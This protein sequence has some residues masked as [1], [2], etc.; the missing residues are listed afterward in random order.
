MNELNISSL[1]QI[2]QE[3]FVEHDKQESAGRFLLESVTLQEDSLCTT[4]L[5]S[6]KIS[7][8]VKR[9]DPVPDDI[10]QAALK[11]DIAVKVEEYFRQ[12][13]IPDINPYTKDDM[14]QKIMN[15]IIQ[16]SEIA[17]RKKDEFQRLYDLGDDTYFLCSVFMYAL[18]RNNRIIINT[19]EYQ[20]APLLAEV[21]YECPLSHEKLVEEVKGIPKKKYEI[22]Q[23]F[24][25]DL[26]Q[27][28][29]EA[30][31]AVYPKPKNYDAPENLIAL[32]IEESENYLMSPTV[33]EYK[34]LYEIK[35]I[36]SKQYKAVN[37]INRIDL[38][39]EIRDAI[40]GLVSI[41]TSDNLPQLEYDAL[42]I[43]QKINDALLMNEVQNHVLQYY[44]Y[45][46]NIFS[47][48][49]D[50]FDDIAG[51]VKI[52]SQKLERAGMSQEAVI[53]NLT[54]WIHNKAFAGT[55]RGKMA[56]KIVVCFFIQNCEVFYK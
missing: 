37:A 48:M 49:T 26:P 12:K 45:I 5:N 39:E 44:R 40:D 15:V 8:L 47:D 34:K 28:L 3:G 32:S 17:K 2:M 30:F 11:A 38:E 31:D 16:D 20:D 10:K 36:T 22:T 6:K 19:V 9:K 51:E 25:D 29:A 54:E 33:E 55:D 27:D 24:P 23:I 56:C 46:E 1:I 43:D 18:Q 50:A 14:F 41:K 42:R 53:Y 21:T 35:Q 4:D 13:V 7:R 52:S